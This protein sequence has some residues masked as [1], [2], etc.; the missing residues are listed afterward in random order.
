MGF[1]TGGSTD[2]QADRRDESMGRFFPTLQTCFKR[3][4]NSRASATSYDD[5]D[6]DDDNNNNKYNTRGMPQQA[7]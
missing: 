3:V 6:D 2:R 1:Q 4:Q 5:D 7:R